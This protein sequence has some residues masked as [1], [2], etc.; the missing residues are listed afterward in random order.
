ML[1]QV[2]PDAKKIGTIYTSSEKNSEVQVGILEEVAA[3][4]GLTIVKRTISSVNDIQQAAQSLIGEVDAVWLPTDN[5]VASA[6]PQVVSVTDEAGLVTLGGEESQVLAG[7]TLTYGINFYQIG[8]DAGVM[9]AQILDGES[10]PA[11]MPIQDPS[12]LK[13]VINTDAVENIGITIPQEL[14][15]Q[16]EMVTTQSN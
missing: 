6:M 9:A 4:K 10:V 12:E 15:D 13:L 5:N 1:L 8:Y 3:E 7:A 16:A 14:L 11:E 2:V